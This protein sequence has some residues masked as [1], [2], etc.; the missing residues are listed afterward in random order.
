[1]GL[2]S[3]QPL[4]HAHEAGGLDAWLPRSSS[5]RFEV[6]LVEESGDWKVVW[7]SWTHAE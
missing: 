1:M 4:R 5:W 3:G 6:R 2:V 7:A